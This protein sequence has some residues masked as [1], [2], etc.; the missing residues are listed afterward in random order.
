MQKESWKYKISII[1]CTYQSMSS[2]YH[3]LNNILLQKMSQKDYEVIAISHGVKDAT[4][5]HLFNLIP[6]K[7]RIFVPINPDI[8]YQPN[9]V[10][11]HGISVAEGKLVLFLHDNVD[12]IGRNWLQILWR[13]SKWG[14]NAVYTH[15]L[16]YK[17]NKDGTI[18]RDDDQFGFF[19][20]QDA[21]P[22]KFLKQ[23]GGFDEAYDGDSG[24]DD[25]DLRYR[26]QQEGCEF[27]GTRDL[28][29]IKHNLRDMYP[30]QRTVSN[31]TRN[32]DIFAN[33]G[34]TA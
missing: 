6:N 27:V 21:V 8:P 20:H 4:A 5:G 25:I 9:H 24:M 30:E 19:A 11:N 16:L 15:K 18:E 3:S 22:L 13:K 10:R 31:G 7:K 34:F 12:L 14:K 29:S 23:V 28:L 17:Y 1:L 26:C 32:R 2:L 33:K